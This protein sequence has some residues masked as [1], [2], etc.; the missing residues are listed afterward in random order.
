VDASY[1]YT[2]TQVL[3]AP[4]AFDPLV[5]AGAP[6]LRRPKHAASLL[7][8]FT[9]PRW[10]G[11]LGVTAVG[12]RADSDFLGLLP[13]VTHSAGYA[14][15]DFGVWRAINSRVTAYL[16]VENALNRHYEESAGFPALRANFR[17]GMR[18]RV[19]GE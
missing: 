1:T 9:T 16:N 11:D 15:V 2:S 18:F 3:F 6:L 4:L 8:V 13:P 10:G 14:R 17:A 7:A 19:G 5:S 12:R